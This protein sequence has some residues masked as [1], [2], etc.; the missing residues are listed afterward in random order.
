MLSHACEQLVDCP[1]KGL[2]P[3]E[4]QSIC[5]KMDMIDIFCPS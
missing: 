1:T 5:N 2:H 4:I 3:S